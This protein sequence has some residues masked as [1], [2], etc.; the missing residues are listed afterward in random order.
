MRWIV[1]RLIEV[2]LG[3]AAGALGLAVIAALVSPWIRRPTVVHGMWLLVILRLLVPPVI[4][5]GLLPSPPVDRAQGL[6]RLAG[7]GI[8][9]QDV[10]GGSVPADPKPH[11]PP[12]PLVVWGL[13]AMGVIALGTMRTRRLAQTLAGGRPGDDEFRSHIEAA[14]TTLGVRRPPRI[15]IVPTGIPPMVWAGM[16]RATLVLPQDLIDRLAGPQVQALIAHELAHLKRRDHWTRFAEFGAA[17]LFWWYPVMWWARR[18]LRVAEELCCDSVVSQ[19]FPTIRRDYADCLVTTVEYARSID[20]RFVPGPAMSGLSDLKERITMIMTPQLRGS[21]PRS[22]RILLAAVAIAVLAMAPT[23]TARTP[24]V[25]DGTREV[26]SVEFEDTP[27]REAL[28]QIADLSMTTIAIHPSAVEA[29]L[30]ENTITMS[31]VD[32]PWEQLLSVLLSI[33]DLVPLREGDVIWVYQAEDLPLQDGD[34]LEFRGEH[35]SL[36]L[37]DADVRDVLQTFHELTSLEFDVDPAVDRRVTVELREI[38]WDQALDLILRLS[39]LTYV[40]HDGVMVVSEAR[41]SAGEVFSTQQTL[42]PEDLPN[43]LVGAIPFD[44]ESSGMTEPEWFS[45]PIPGLPEL[46]E[47]DPDSATV[48]VRLLI[49][50]TGDVRHSFVVFGT[51]DNAAALVADAVREW[52]FEPARQDGEPVEVLYTVVLHYSEGR[53]RITGPG[54]S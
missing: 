53:W 6:A 17:V 44:P 23:L 31:V 35:I 40:V 14:A 32:W 43:V 2:A 36:T 12:V 42:A 45:G 54:H 1:D 10:S 19:L 13:G 8:H 28:A 16:G 5:I 11:H 20:S 27:L 29:G 46:D 3:N 22:T 25:E 41:S 48:A 34:P 52:R 33:N 30:A 24:G 37:N 39:G 4:E 26:V 50:A 18:R 9:V 15:R 51:S 21:L 38:P 47:R 49:G 7:P